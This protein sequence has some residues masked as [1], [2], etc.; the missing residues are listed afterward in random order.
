MQVMRD[1]VYKVHVVG[2]IKCTLFHIHL[3]LETCRMHAVVQL[4]VELLS[5]TFMIF[6]MH[7]LN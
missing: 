2:K 6:D 1:C 3:V 7:F 5:W 4:T